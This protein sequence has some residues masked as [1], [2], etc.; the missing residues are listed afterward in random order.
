MKKSQHKTFCSLLME[1]CGMSATNVNITKMC[2]QLGISRQVY[3]AYDTDRKRPTPT[4]IN[5]IVEKLIE[6]KQIAIEVKDKTRA[7]LML[8]AGWAMSAP[9]NADFNNYLKSKASEPVNR[10]LMT[11]YVSRAIIYKIRE[12]KKEYT[13]GRCTALKCAL[14]L[15]LNLEE[16]QR[17]FAFVGFY[18]SES[19]RDDKIIIKNIIEQNFEYDSVIEKLGDYA[20]EYRFTTKIPKNKKLSPARRK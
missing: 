18:L 4:T 5:K 2:R 12:S 17:L 3:Y 7:E 8:A 15:E 11:G 1:Y 20:G 19:R 9:N 13:I 6:N 16:T 14:A 10:L